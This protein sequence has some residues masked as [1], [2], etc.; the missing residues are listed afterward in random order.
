MRLLRRSQL[1]KVR[2]DGSDEL[3]PI[4][5]IGWEKWEQIVTLPKSIVTLKSVRF[6]SL[7]GSDR[8]GNFE[9]RL[10]TLYVPI[11]M[12]GHQLLSWQLSI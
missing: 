4:S 10:H 2:D 6:L 8:V 1:A 7:Y 9:S 5:G 3:D 11:F 12:G